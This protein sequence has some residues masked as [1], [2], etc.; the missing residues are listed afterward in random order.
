MESHVPISIMVQKMPY[1]KPISCHN[2]NKIM[3]TNELSSSSSHEKDCVPVHSIIIIPVLSIYILY[4]I[5]CVLF[6]HTRA[7][8][9]ACV[10]SFMRVRA[11]VRACVCVCV[12]VYTTGTI[13]VA[14]PDVHVDIEADP[15]QVMWPRPCDPRFDVCED[16]S[17][18]PGLLLTWHTANCCSIYK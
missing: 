11:C 5:S 9:R 16:K 2:Q 8:V 4:H 10:H 13:V 18:I 12:C 17:V 7:C 6:V 14:Y 3:H 15:R 1:I